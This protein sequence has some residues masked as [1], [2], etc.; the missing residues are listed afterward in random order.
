M[1]LQRPNQEIIKQLLTY[2]VVKSTALYKDTNLIT[3][4]KKE[5]RKMVQKL[6]SFTDLEMLHTEKNGNTSQ[7]INLELQ[8]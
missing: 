3:S 8:S 7:K 6:G 2:E 1:Y 5:K 4:I